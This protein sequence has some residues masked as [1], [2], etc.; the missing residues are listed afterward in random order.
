MDVDVDVDVYSRVQ[1][2]QPSTDVS[3]GSSTVHLLSALIGLHTLHSAVRR[4]T[5]AHS[6]AALPLARTS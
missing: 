2:R 5:D 3:E 6:P 1:C 4:G